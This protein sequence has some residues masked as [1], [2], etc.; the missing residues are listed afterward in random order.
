MSDPDWVNIESAKRWL[1]QRFNGNPD[2]GSPLYQYL[3]HLGARGRDVD[4]RE[5]HLTTYEIMRWRKVNS[6]T[7][8]V[9][10]AGELDRKV[11]YPEHQPPPYDSKTR[12]LHDSEPLLN[13]AKAPENESPRP[14]TK[15][16]RAAK[17]PSQQ[18][19]IEASRA[20]LPSV[21]APKKTTHQS[22][23][24]EHLNL[25]ATRQCRLRLETLR[26][27]IGGRTHGESGKI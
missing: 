16:D 2:A 6:I 24:V 19:T 20:T 27:R 13:P 12:R 9:C 3:N 7:G 25:E 11:F 4:G 23:R 17:P 14:R 22:Q 10:Y 18:K 1:E 15:G 8:R 5:E 21:K 26:P